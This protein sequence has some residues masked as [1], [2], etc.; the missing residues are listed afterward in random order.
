MEIKTEN[1]NIPINNIK[2]LKAVECAWLAGLFQAEAYFYL[3]K[4]QRAK[5][6]GYVPPPPN[7]QIKLEMIEKDLME[8]I[9]EYLNKTVILTTRKTSAGN[10][11]YKITIT[12][13]DEVEAFLLAIQP[14]VVGNKVSSKINELLDACEQHKQWLAK[15]GKSNVARIANLAS[16][17]SRRNSRQRKEKQE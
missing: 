6:S 13:R 3:D 4:R 9:G 12:K 15:G 16:Q 2:N 5:T 1:I 11:V 7:P 17:K 14:Y 10:Q 8:K